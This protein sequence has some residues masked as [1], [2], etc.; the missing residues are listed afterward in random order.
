MFAQNFFGEGFIALKAL[1]P[2]TTL[3]RHAVI[4]TLLGAALAIG[5]LDLRKDGHI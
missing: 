2:S 5:C 3:L 1:S 4:F